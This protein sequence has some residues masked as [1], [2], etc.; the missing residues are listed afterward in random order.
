MS[1][2]YLGT[3]NA[4]SCWEGNSNVPLPAIVD[5]STEKIVH[6]MDEM[7]FPFCK[8]GDTLITRFGMNGSLHDYLNSIGFSFDTNRYSLDSEYDLNFSVIEL[9]L[10]Q[11]ERLNP[12]LKKTTSVSAYATDSDMGSLLKVIQNNG[13]LPRHETAVAVNSKVYSHA[14]HERIG[15]RPVGTVVHSFLQLT[16]VT[17]DLLKSGPI[18]LKSPHGVSGK[19]NLLVTTPKILKRVL[20]YFE[21]QA[22]AGKDLLFIVEPLLNK[23]HDFSSQLSISSQGKVDFHSVQRMDNSGFNYAGSYSADTQFVSELKEKGYFDTI[24]KVGQTLFEDGY[25]G[26]V[27][28]DSMI[29]ED[30]TVIPIVEIN[31]RKSMGLINY[32]L[33]T[34]CQK[35][36]YTSTL[37][38]YSLGMNTMLSFESFITQLQDASLL[39]NPEKGS[40]VIP[41]CSNALTINYDAATRLGEDIN[42]SKGRFYFSIASDSSS[43]KIQVSKELQSFLNGLEY[44]IYNSGS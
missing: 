15:M 18:L 26:D 13:V 30:D 39:F 6:C 14:I 27:C 31:A 9:A 21:K 36:G 42:H 8:S 43:Q 29:L 7:L 3:F 24:E 5:K 40:G 35:Y 10:Q 44:T 22:K 1:T 2:L 4:E 12:I 37:G 28:I 11:R 32:T 16:Q 19:G 17:D 23:K 34:H 20:R 25:F 41:L 33:D 38:F